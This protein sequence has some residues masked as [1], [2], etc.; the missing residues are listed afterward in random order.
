M[1][2]KRKRINNL[3]I[4]IRISININNIKVNVKELKLKYIIILKIIQNKIIFNINKKLINNNI[5]T[6][7]IQ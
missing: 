4:Y 1:I 5:N 3:L 7:S 6:N 2:I